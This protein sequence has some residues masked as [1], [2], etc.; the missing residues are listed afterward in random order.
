M[1]AKGAD[2]T[3][4]GLASKGYA[5]CCHGNATG[6]ADRIRLAKEKH[7]PEM[8]QHDGRRNSREEI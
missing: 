5:E 6:G 7:G 8:Y 2:L 1:A 3:R 4:E